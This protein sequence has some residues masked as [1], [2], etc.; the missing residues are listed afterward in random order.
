MGVIRGTRPM[1]ALAE[2]GIVFEVREDQPGGERNIS[3]AKD[4]PLTVAPEPI[5]I[6]SGLLA[7]RH[8]PERL[9]AWASFALTAS[10][11]VDLRPLELWPEGD[12]LLNAL[13]DASFDGRIRE[14]SLRVASALAG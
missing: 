14:S 13:W 6:A 12:E 8:D 4:S 3:L 2:G 9:R 10:E 1:S 11:V 5:D 7:Y